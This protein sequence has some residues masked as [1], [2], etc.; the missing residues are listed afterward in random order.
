MLVACIKVTTGKEFHKLQAAWNVKA[1]K[2]GFHKLQATCNVKEAK[3]G[4]RIKRKN[5]GIWK[6]TS[7][8]IELKVTKNVVGNG[9]LKIF[10]SVKWL[11]YLLEGLKSSSDK[12]APK[13]MSSV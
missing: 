6:G 10:C 4:K 3:G 8:M 5:R 9:F 13:S 11:Q 2:R 1:S 12:V 7:Q